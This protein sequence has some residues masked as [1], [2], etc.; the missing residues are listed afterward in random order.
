MIKDNV[1]GQVR[2]QLV[3]ADNYDF[4][5]KAGSD[6]IPNSVGPYLYNPKATTYW[7]PGRKL[8]KTST[9]IPPDSSVTVKRTRDAL[10]WL[11]ALGAHVHHVYFGNDFT[12]VSEATPNSPEFKAKI[13]NDGNVYYLEESLQ[14]STQYFWRVDAEVSQG[15]IYKGDVW[16]FTTKASN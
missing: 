1:V 3:D 10:M 4:R 8:Y 16:S 2:Q 5:P 11:N 7:I 13:E 6:Y 15:E 12:K 14:Q 9:P